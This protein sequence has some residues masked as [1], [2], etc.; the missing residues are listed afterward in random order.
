MMTRYNMGGGGGCPFKLQWKAKVWASI[1]GPPH[2]VQGGRHGRGKELWGR[3]PGQGRKEKCGFPACVG[4]Y[5]P[6]A[7][8]QPNRDQKS[9]GF[10]TW[11]HKCCLIAPSASIPALHGSS[12]MHGLTRPCWKYLKCFHSALIFIFFLLAFIRLVTILTTWRQFQNQAHH[13]S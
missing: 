13:A 9:S 1:C 8:R 5:S 4:C 7:G 12:G 3:T 10:R 11:R 6:A 2:A